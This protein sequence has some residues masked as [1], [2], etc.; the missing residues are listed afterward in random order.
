MTEVTRVPLKPVAPGSLTKLWVG[1]ALAILIGAGLALAAVPINWNQVEVIEEVPA[2]DGEGT[3]SLTIET[4]REGSGATAEEGQVVFVKYRGILADDGTVFDEY[5]PITLPVEGVFSEGTPFPV[6]ENQTID[7]FFM[8]LQ[9]MRKGGEYKLFIPSELGYGET[10]RPGSPIP[11]G[12]DLIFEI[13]VMDIISQQ[14]FEVGMGI[15]QQA[16][17]AS[18]PGIPGGPPAGPPQGIGE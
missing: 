3:V 7:G 9:Q 2:V 18:N 4:V 16:I 10:P 15:L 1:V 12:A 8:G 6:I 14:Q 5:T 17:Q 13:E 11:P